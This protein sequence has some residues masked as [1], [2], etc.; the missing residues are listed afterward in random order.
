[1]VTTTH[2][3]KLMRE[4]LP[5]LTEKVSQ[6]PL[7]ESLLPMCPDHPEHFSIAGFGYAGGGFGPYRMCMAN[8][9]TG[10]C[11]RIFDKKS[12]KDGNDAPSIRRS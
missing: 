8:T 7:P 2:E 1:M 9:E 3:L 5:Y 12:T 6:R 4:H 11:K 10:I